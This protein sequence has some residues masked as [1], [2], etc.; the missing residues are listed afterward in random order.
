MRHE[1]DPSIGRYDT[2]NTSNSQKRSS[3]LRGA[4]EA[5]RNDIDYLTV[6]RPG[7]TVL[8]IMEN[9]HYTFLAWTPTRSFELFIVPLHQK[10]EK[11]SLANILNTVLQSTHE[12]VCLKPSLA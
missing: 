1:G 4:L 9:I 12:R 7:M 3:S 10:S 8:E 6:A 5:D 11:V 2:K